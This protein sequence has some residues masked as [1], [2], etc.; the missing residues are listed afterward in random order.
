MW[1][2]QKQR[3]ELSLQTFFLCREIRVLS[4]P[5]VLPFSAQVHPLTL[6]CIKKGKLLSFP[7]KHLEGFDKILTIRVP[8]MVFFWISVYSQSPFKS[9]VCKRS[10]ISQQVPNK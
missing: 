9:S 7:K 8:F 6:T 1:S 5:I 3:S 2:K 4:F 10:I